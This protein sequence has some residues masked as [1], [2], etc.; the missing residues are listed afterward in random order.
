MNTSQRLGMAI[1][2]AGGVS[3]V[4]A[5]RAIADYT[6]T[7]TYTGNYY[8]NFGGG[9]G[10]G[11]N[12]FGTAPCYTEGSGC[13]PTES[14]VGQPNNPE[15]A[16]MIISLTYAAPLPNNSISDESPEY[17]TFSGNIYGLQ[18]DDVTVAS[19]SIQTNQSGNIISWDIFAAS[20]ASQAPAYF[21]NT[22]QYLSNSSDGV[23]GDT[24]CT[25]YQD[26]CASSSSP[27]TW[28][29]PVPGPI[30]GAGI[31]GLVFACGGLLVWW[32]TRWPCRVG[33]PRE[34]SGATS[35]TDQ[36]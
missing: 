14:W 1:V 21:P 13:P 31:P 4:G 9:N 25:S 3:A 22:V 35:H 16:N 7:Y 17:Y 26:S 5:A 29:D 19:F 20:A 30:P 24:V 11:A 34:Q 10:Y 28:S 18:P 15:A 6:Y 2:V 8:T 12:A 27:G 36:E 33:E 23:G 32:R